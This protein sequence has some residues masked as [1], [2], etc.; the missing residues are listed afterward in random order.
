MFLTFLHNIAIVMEK[1]SA[2]LIAYNEAQWIKDYLHQLDFVDEIV[3][4]DSYSTDEIQKIALKNP[5]VRFYKRAFDNF[6]NQRN[7]ALSLAQHSWVLFLDADEFIT[8]AL[9][10]E[11]KHRVQ[12]PNGSVAFKIKRKF[13]FLGKPIHFSGLNLDQAYR[14]FDKRFCRYDDK[15]FVHERLIV[16]G[17]SEVLQGTLHHYSVTNI[18]TYKVKL[19]YYSRLKASQL[20]KENLKPT[21]FHFY[22]KPSV[23]FFI[24]YF[25]KLGILDGCAGLQLAYLNAKAVYLRYYYLNKLIKNI[26]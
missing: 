16:D 2:L 13:Y 11:I 26:K 19:D 21:A 23:R 24:Q 14:L 25:I 17:K 5:K 7:Y 20:H 9:E 8:P 3:I 10:E 1:I 15:T 6:A 22:I 12:H 4:V 18:N